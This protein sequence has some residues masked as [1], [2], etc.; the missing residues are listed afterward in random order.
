MCISSMDKLSELIK[1]CKPRIFNL[2]CTPLGWYA[3]SENDGFTRRSELRT[4][5]ETAV[6]ELL[7]KLKG[8]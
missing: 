8:I 1:E 5:P 4:T 2:A 3:Q 6:A 7:E